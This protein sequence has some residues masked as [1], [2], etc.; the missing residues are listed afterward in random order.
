MKEND[1]RL[2]RLEQSGGNNDGEFPGDNSPKVAELPKSDVF[3]AVDSDRETCLGGED[4]EEYEEQRRIQRAIN[5]AK[6]DNIV[7]ELNSG[8]VIPKRLHF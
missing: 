1:E 5:S 6:A 4:E 3:Y 8:V 2:E 7:A